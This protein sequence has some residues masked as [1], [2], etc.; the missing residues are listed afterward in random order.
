MKSTKK[1]TVELTK[2]EVQE[3][4]IMWLTKHETD[5]VHITNIDSIIKRTQ[6]PGMDIHDCD[7]REEFDGIKV[8]GY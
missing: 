3:A 7:W 8:T 2:A 4:I 1:V 5:I 6:I